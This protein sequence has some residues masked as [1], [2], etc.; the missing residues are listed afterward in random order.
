[1]KKIVIILLLF[2][3]LIFCNLAN[4]TVSQKR[5]PGE[6]FQEAIKRITTR[7]P[8]NSLKM[9]LAKSTPFSK[10]VPL[11]K[12]DY[13]TVPAVSSYDELINMFHMIRDTRFL[14]SPGKPDFERRISWLYPDDGCFARAALSR[15]KLDGEHFVIPAKIF[16]FGNLEMQTPYSEDGSVSW[17]YH[18]SIVVNYMGSIYVLDP[19]AKSDGPMLIE[20]WYNKIGVVDEMEAV[21]CNPYTYDPFDRCYDATAKSDN[22]ALNDQLKYLDKEWARIESLG[23]DPAVLLGNNPPWIVQ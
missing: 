20:D 16:A 1:M 6:S 8:Q 22:K 12:I 15:V 4:A 19:A 9:L 17:W 11:Q 2:P 23:F 3:F 14:Y 7:E 18:V 10:K 13:S 5:Y 21:V